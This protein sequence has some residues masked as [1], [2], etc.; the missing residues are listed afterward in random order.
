[1]IFLYIFEGLI[2]GCGNWDSWCAF[3]KLRWEDC[4]NRGV[5]GHR[6]TPYDK[7]ALT[8]HKLFDNEK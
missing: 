7:Q 2:V 1:M 4:G 5:G 6:Q 3:T 8:K